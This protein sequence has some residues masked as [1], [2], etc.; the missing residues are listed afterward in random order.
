VDVNDLHFPALGLFATGVLDVLPT[1][2]HLTLNTAR[3][4]R[5]GFYS[6][7][8]LVDSSGKWFRIVSARKLHGVG[9]FGGYSLFLGQRIRVELELEDEHRE[10]TLNE[11]RNLI[12]S[13]FATSSSWQSRDDVQ[14][15]QAQIDSSRTIAELLQR[16]A[17]AV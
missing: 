9:P 15:L 4:L 12:L 13:E 17:Q 6:G 10:A 7:Y 2:N 8:E 3:G 1:A 11:V 5:D 16:L 14:S